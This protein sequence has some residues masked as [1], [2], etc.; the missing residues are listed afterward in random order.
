MG[1]CRMNGPEP[2]N[3]NLNNIKIIIVILLIYIGIN[4]FPF[5]AGVLDVQR[6]FLKDRCE[7]KLTRIEYIIPG[8]RAG[9]YMGSVP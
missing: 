1:S 6:P 4:L 7:S 5:I 2:T 9:C 3:N 8:Y